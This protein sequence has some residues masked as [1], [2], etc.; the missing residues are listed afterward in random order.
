M[1]K[2]MRRPERAATVARLALMKLF[3]IPPLPP[4]T[5]QMRA[6]AGAARSDRNSKGR[7]LPFSQLGV[8]VRRIDYR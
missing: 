4:P 3:P 5:A 1:L 8:P 2:L 7:V 6:R